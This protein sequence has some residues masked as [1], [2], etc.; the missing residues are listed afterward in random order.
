MTSKSDLPI[1][2]S[3][4]YGSDLSWIETLCIQSYL[5]RGHRFVLYTT[6]ELSGVPTGAEVRSAA[7]ILWPAPFDISDNDRL[8]VAVFSDIF[9]L[10]LIQDTGFVWVDLDAYCVRPF[11]FETPYI[12]AQSKK[13]KFPNGVMGL[14]RDS[15]A[16][17]AMIGFLTSQNPSQP[18]RGSRLR[19]INRHRIEQGETWG[20]ETLPWG[21]SGPKAFAYFLKQSGE[22]RLAMHCD[23]FYPLAPDELWQLHAPQITTEMIEKEGVYSVHIYGHQKKIIANHLSGLPVTGSYLA[24]LCKR[25]GIDPR[26]QIVPRLRWME[27]N[28]MN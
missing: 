17:S 21:C 1:I 24:R 3:F 4:W 7:E 26:K 22:D 8:R 12:F 13:G 25:H 18:W 23:T 5:D 2:A 19:Q 6:T 15:R 14:P 16:L 9:R 20:I 28:A 10:R 27:Q 11:D